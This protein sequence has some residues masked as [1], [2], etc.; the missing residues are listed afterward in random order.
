MAYQSNGVVYNWESKSGQN[1][2]PLL[3]SSSSGIHLEYQVERSE[4]TLMSQRL[5][6]RGVKVFHVI[7][8]R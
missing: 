8:L 2:E 5:R 4:G 3:S 6:H 1:E 7:Y